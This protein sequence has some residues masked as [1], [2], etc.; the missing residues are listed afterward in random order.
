M[1]SVV[2]CKDGVTAVDGNEVVVEGKGQLELSIDGKDLLIECLVLSKLIPAFDL[3]I[4]MDVIAKLNGVCIDG[5]S[6]QVKFGLTATDTLVI[7][8]VDFEAKFDGSRWTIKWKWLAGEP[9]LSNQIGSYGV[10]CVT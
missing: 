6:S 8:D 9:V 2:D 3:I 5:N 7:D 1:Q 4:G 10:S